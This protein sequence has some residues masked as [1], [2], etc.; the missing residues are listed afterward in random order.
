MYWIEE[1]KKKRQDGSVWKCAIETEK[2]TFASTRNSELKKI[3]GFHTRENNMISLRTP[4][5]TELI[6]V[7]YTSNGS[8]AVRSPSIGRT[9]KTFGMVSSYPCIRCLVP[10]HSWGRLFTSLVQMPFAEVVSR[11][12][13]WAHDEY[14]EAEN[15]SPQ[16]HTPYSAKPF[17][18]WHTRALDRERALTYSHARDFKRF[19]NSFWSAR[20]S[21]ILCISGVCVY[22]CER[23]CTFE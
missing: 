21:S 12:C 14:S 7:A 19:V 18:T 9:I 5:C 4:L 2:F 10:A 20:R 8:C 1:K 11:T 15:R 16:I 13:V 6:S 23:I 22:V 17:S 3:W